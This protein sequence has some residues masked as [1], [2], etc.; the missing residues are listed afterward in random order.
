MSG[1]DGTA[2]RA[3]RTRE[4]PASDR[5]PDQAE[6]L[7]SGDIAVFNELE[8]RVHDAVAAL[9][10]RQRQV[11]A[12]TLAGFTTTQIARQLG[13][14]QAAVRQNQV[15]GRDSLARQLGIDRRRSQ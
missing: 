5:L 3:A 11:M 13:C 12:L 9:P 2:P 1:H 15:R 10:F 14:D 8:H 6:P 4:T 7:N